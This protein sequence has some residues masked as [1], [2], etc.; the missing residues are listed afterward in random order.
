MS[1]RV[2][3]AKSFHHEGQEVRKRS[4]FLLFVFVV[5]SLLFPTFALAQAPFFQGKTITI[6]HGKGS[7]DLPQRVLRTISITSAATGTSP[8]CRQRPRET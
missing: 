6:V 3:I 5:S 4:S 1:G 7:K 2:K 8:A